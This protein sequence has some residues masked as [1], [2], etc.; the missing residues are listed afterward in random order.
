[1]E[2]TVDRW[3]HRVTTGAPVRMDGRLTWRAP[4]LS[5]SLK[6]S[7]R[8]ACAA[9]MG[10]GVSIQMDSNEC[11]GRGRAIRSQAWS[12]AR[13][14]VGGRQVRGEGCWSYGNCAT[15]S[16]SPRNCTSDGL[17]SGSTSPARVQPADQAL[18]QELGVQ[19]LDRTSR[20]VQL[21]EPGRLF[22][23]LARGLLD[24]AND[25]IALVRQA[26]V[27][28]MIQ[29]GIEYDPQPPFD[30]GRPEGVAR[31][32]RVGEVDDAA[33]TVASAPAAR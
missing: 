10:S 26:E 29:L 13:P 9:T 12:T 6:T 30:T 14:L 2:A 27:A 11:R 17:P 15:S 31:H 32:G 5:V 24:Q 20:R 23:D 3:R 1:M 8:V 18:E 33:P 4:W 25:A 21:T 16:P 19:L 22:V 7:D 28:Q